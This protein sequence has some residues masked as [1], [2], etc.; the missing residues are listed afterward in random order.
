LIEKNLKKIGKK[1]NIIKYFVIKKINDKILNVFVGWSGMVLT[2]TYQIFFRLG[3]FF[4]TFS[5]WSGMM[6]IGMEDV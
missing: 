6:L 1:Y 3:F 4:F 2:S 5:S